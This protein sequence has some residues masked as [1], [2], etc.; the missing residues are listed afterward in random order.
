MINIYFN[1][2]LDL[3]SIYILKN[4][5]DEKTRLIN[6]RKSSLKYYHKN[7]NS[8]KYKKTQ[9][10]Y[11]T[12]RRLNGLKYYYNNKEKCIKNSVKWSENNP[13]KTKQ[14]KQKYYYKNKYK[15]EIYFIK[16]SN[17]I[18]NINI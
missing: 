10:E 1:Y 7:K 15:K 11:V 16:K 6:R 3:K 12:H 2:K 4:M 14:F 13:I 17:I 5:L 8:E 18:N 9:S